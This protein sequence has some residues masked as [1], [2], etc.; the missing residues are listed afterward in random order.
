MHAKLC[1]FHMKIRIE[2]MQFMATKNEL[3]RSA[4][5]YCGYAT[6]YRG[7][8]MINKLDYSAVF[9]PYCW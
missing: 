6:L 8:D 5:F 9:V 7:L 3:D 2:P 1:T 4:V